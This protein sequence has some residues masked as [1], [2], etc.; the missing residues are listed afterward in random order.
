[1]RYKKILLFFL[2]FIS[3]TTKTFSADTNTKQD[4]EIL[5]SQKESFGISSFIQEAEKYTKDTFDDISMNEVLNS[6]ILG[7][8]DNNTLFERII[9]MFG[10]EIKGMLKVLRYYFSYY[11]YT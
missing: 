2:I 1:M 4:N 5:N 6:A 11:C 7:E 10:K 8:V 9:Q 3:I